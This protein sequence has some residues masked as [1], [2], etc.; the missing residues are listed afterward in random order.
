[1][2]HVTHMTESCH[3]HECPRI[4]VC[5]ITYRSDSCCTC[6]RGMAHINELWHT[7]ECAHINHSCHTL[8]WVMSHIWMSQGTYM[9]ELWHM[10]EWVMAHIWISHALSRIWMRHVTRFTGSC[11]TDE[12]VRARTWTSYGTSMNESWHTYEW[13]MP[14]HAYECAMSHTYFSLHWSIYAYNY[15]W[16]MSRTNVPYRKYDWVMSHTYFSFPLSVYIYACIQGY[17]RIG[18]NALCGHFLRVGMRACVRVYVFALNIKICT[19][20]CVYELVYVDDMTHPWQV[21]YL[22][23]A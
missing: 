7:Y 13:V 21:F 9:N 11:H 1:M 18:T 2:N 8:Y 20:E 4:W 10:Y 16:V 6:H 3:A 12:W 14:C 17:M 15:K 5:H 22:N 23:W 19:R